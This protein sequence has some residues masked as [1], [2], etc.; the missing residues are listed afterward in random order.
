MRFFLPFL[1]IAYASSDLG[2]KQVTDGFSA[3]TSFSISMISMNEA[4]ELMKAFKSDSKIPFAYGIDGCS[5]RATI[6]AQI[7]HEKRLEIGKVFVK[8]TLYAD[9]SKSKLKP[10]LKED[11]YGWTNHVAPVVYVKNGDKTEIMI[12]D[13]SIADQPMTVDEFK[14]AVTSKGKPNW[15]DGK[16]KAEPQIERLYFGSRFQDRSYEE[17]PAKIPEHD[18]NTIKHMAY[19][20]LANIDYMSTPGNSWLNVTS[21]D[22]CEKYGSYCSSQKKGEQI[23]KKREEEKAKLSAQKPFQSC[24]GSEI[25]ELS[26]NQAGLPDG[27]QNTGDIAATILSEDQATELMESFKKNKKIPFNDS[28]NCHLRAHYMLQLAKEKGITLS[29]IFF[30][31]NLNAKKLNAKGEDPIADYNNWIMHVVP[32]AVVRG[33]DGILRKKILDPSLV[34]SPTELNEFK[35]KLLSPPKYGKPASINKIYCSDQYQL[36]AK[37]DYDAKL[38]PHDMSQITKDILSKFE[39]IQSKFGGD[40]ENAIREPGVTR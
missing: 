19:N 15:S 23:R 32:L 13:P 24:D 30:E 6:M 18:M 12:L 17:Y 26:G 5:Q 38:P 28:D 31:G 20:R 10:K 9:N 27:F 7:A 1:L 22:Y 3:G 4:Q 25:K 35:H 33:K 37:K 21:E 8:G 34:E 16:V 40:V 11:V 29:K 36:E 2:K 39:V 14:A